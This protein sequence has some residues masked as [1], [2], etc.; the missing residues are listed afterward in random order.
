MR[1]K[2]RM[3]LLRDT[4]AYISDGLVVPVQF[5]P[6]TLWCAKPITEDSVSSCCPRHMCSSG[7]QNYRL[8]LSL[9]FF[10]PLLRQGK[11]LFALTTSRL[12][13]QLSL[14]LFCLTPE[15][16]MRLKR[17]RWDMHRAHVS[18]RPDKCTDNFPPPIPNA[19]AVPPL[20]S[21]PKC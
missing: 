21:I 7:C 11:Y 18:T 8:G 1:S 15:N 13:L 9:D 6:L 3:H 5:Q 12:A 2:Q 20:K 17:E 19:K 16:G 4:A 10:P 14:V